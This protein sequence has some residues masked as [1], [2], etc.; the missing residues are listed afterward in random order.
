MGKKDSTILLN[1]GIRYSSSNW[2]IKYSQK[3]PFSWPNEFYNGITSSNSAITWALSSIFRLKP[4]WS[5]QALIPTA[6]RSPNI[7]DI[8]K[9]RVKGD[10]VSIPNLSLNPEKSTNYE[11]SLS[12]S[13]NNFLG[14]PNSKLNIS[15]TG[16]YTVLS[17]A[18]VREFYALPDGSDFLVDEGDT[19]HTVANI[20]AGEAYIYGWSANVN[21]HINPQW[22][23]AGS[24]N[25]LK[26]R[27]KESGED[28]PLSHIPPL[29][30]KVS[31]NYSF[32]DWV[33]KALWSFNFE[34]NIKDY[35]GSEDNLDKATPTGTPGW[36]T[37][38]LYI[39]KQIIPT[40]KINL[41]F[42]NLL[43]Q[44]YRPFASGVSAPG[45]NAIISINGQF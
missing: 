10:E 17:D 25:F 43:D 32:K 39:S 44:H 7:D 41:G 4:S 40:V 34:K 31:S 14:N 27:V 1:A 23:W 21:Y 30:G 35:G 42:E 36:S 13:V 29:Y 2:D 28:S 38:N 20:N 26:G 15:T 37:I 22:N 19:L 3:D 9:I 5:I 18:I 45:F 33:F 12:K 8:G 11:L 16:F 6:F 24:I